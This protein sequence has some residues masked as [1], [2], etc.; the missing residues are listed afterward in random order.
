MKFWLSFIKIQDSVKGTKS[1]AELFSMAALVLEVSKIQFMTISMA[2]MVR[3]DKLKVFR[4]GKNIL[5]LAKEWR[6]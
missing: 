4:Q 5:L 6:Y 2:V 1:I 3:E